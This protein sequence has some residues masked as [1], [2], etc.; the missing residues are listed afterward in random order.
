MSSRRVHTLYLTAPSDSLIRQGAILLE[1]TL[2]VVSLPEP[3]GGRVLL[4]RSLNLGTIDSR[5]SSASLSLIVQQ[6]LR[7]LSA[8][9]VHAA[10]PA[11]AHSPAVY[12]RNDA[13]PCIALALRLAKGQPA[14]EWFWRLAVSSYEPTQARNATLRQILFDIR[15]TRAGVSA[16][17]ALV[18]ALLQNDA[19][20][21]LLSTLTSQD[22]SVLHQ[23]CRWQLPIAPHPVAAPV[24]DLL[25]PS[26]IE[27]GTDDLRS[28]WLAAIVLVAENPARLLDTNLIAKAW[29]GVRSLSKTLHRSQEKT[30]GSNHTPDT[31]SVT[32]QSIENL[33]SSEQKHTDSS[34]TFNTDAYAEFSLDRELQE[35]SVNPLENPASNTGT[36]DFV[37]TAPSGWTDAP[38]FT[39]YAGLFF[40]LPLLDSLD[41][42]T[43]LES[44]PDLI[45]INF[46]RHL[47]QT[48]AHRFSIPPT[49][50]IWTALGFPQSPIPNPFS[51]TPDRSVA[52]TS[53]PLLTWRTT[54]RRACRRRAQMGLHNLI[55][56][57]GRVL[58][59]RTHLDL[60][61]QH[62][63]ADIR[64]RR[65]GLDLDPGWLSWWGQVV[66]FHYIDGHD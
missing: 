28:I 36:Q 10:A 59:T 24:P 47:L 62:E 46:P 16:I 4:V 61:F 31:C 58:V 27:W 49:D 21:P 25:H 22:G 53:D 41:I 2:H 23:I 32:P 34:Q 1:D 3:E 52:S 48:I 17:V 37:E 43:F 35:T 57:P 45:E 5:Q 20:V 13:E 40:L 64:L 8:I 12:F 42:A 54:L 18:Q 60:W 50:P 29:G 19:I 51:K 33:Q 7:Q 55:C 66:A 39:A 30:Y 63:Q 38:C 6:R 9:A 26:I 65:T 44:H 14:T 56:R 15:H 11:A